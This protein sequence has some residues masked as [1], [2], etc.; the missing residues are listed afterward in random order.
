MSY[1][2]VYHK[3]IR[4]QTLA[5]RHLKS[6]AARELELATRKGSGRLSETGRTESTYIAGVVG[7]V[8]D[9]KGGDAS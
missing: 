9:V 5:R 1:A 6:V 7:A 2:N 4:K 8:E 3:R